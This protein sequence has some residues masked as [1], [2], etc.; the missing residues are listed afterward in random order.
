M[1]SAALALLVAGVLAGCG[2]TYYFA[3]RVLPPSGLTS[4]V[5]IAIQNPSAFTRGAL[6]FVDSYYD[7][8]SSYNYKVASYSIGGYSGS[9]PVT[10]QNMPEE[11]IGAVYGAGDGSLTIANYA[12]EKTGGS[13]AGLNGLSQSVFLTRNQAFAFAASQNAHVLS[14]SDRNAGA[15]YS[16]SLPGIYR[17]S[18]NPGGTVALIFQQNTNFLYYPMKLTGQQTAMYAGGPQNWPVGAVD[19]EPQNAP[20]FCLYQALD[21]A[22][23]K[24]NL[25]PLTFDR[26]IKAVFSADGSTAYILNCGP[27]CGGNKASYTPI[28]ISPMIFLNGQAAGTLPSAAAVAAATVPVPGGAS[29]A[30]VDSSTMYVVGQCIAGENLVDDLPACASAGN[31]ASPTN[32]LFTGMLSVVDLST[33]TVGAANSIS[34]GVPMGPSR[35]ILADDNTLWVGMTKCTNG[36]RAANNLPFGCLTMYNTSTQSV[37]MLESYIGDLTGIAAVTNL[38]KIYV[39]QGGQVYIYSTVDGSLR[40]NQYVTVT[41]TAMD[42]AYMDAVT[43]GNNTVY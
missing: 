11:Q 22:S 34:D 29:N 32:P 1:L 14:V 20:G 26:P 39:A 33:N 42:V 37:T 43:D 18:V 16:L 17:V 30:L 12:T 31:P 27:E 21:P 5:L 10:I 40:N 35:M 8:R 41:G 36:A 28:L 4:R 7:I 24:T 25:I 15:A 19:C 9:L 23:T 3:G 2:N 6:Q 13:V 38:H